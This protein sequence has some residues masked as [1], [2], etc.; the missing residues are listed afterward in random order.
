MSSERRKSV[1]GV[2]ASAVM[3]AGLLAAQSAAAEGPCGDYS[4]SAL[5]HAPYLNN[6]GYDYYPFFP[7]GFFGFSH[8]EA[9]GYRYGEADAWCAAR[10]HTYNPATHTYVGFGGHLR[11]CP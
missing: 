5:L 3:G 6:Y 8:G 11:H 4:C 7:Y 10:F 1:A 2:I 9:Y